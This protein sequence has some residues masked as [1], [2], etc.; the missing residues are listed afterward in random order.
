MDTHTHTLP[1]ILQT[2]L[3]VWFAGTGV[4]KLV[5]RREQLVTTLDRL[6]ASIAVPSLEVAVQ[7]R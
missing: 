4:V 5:R 7:H 3:A 2:I 1:L 6:H